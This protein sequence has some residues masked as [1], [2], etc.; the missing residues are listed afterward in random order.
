MKVYLISGPKKYA[1]QGWLFEKLKRDYTNVIS[2]YTREKDNKPQWLEKL[3]RYKV[4]I[5]VFLHAN[6]DDLIIIYDNDIIGLYLGLLFHIFR[7][8]MVVYKINAM[9]SNKEHPY[10]S[11]KRIFVR[12]AYENIFTSV[13][14]DNIASLYSEFFNLPIRHFI[15]IPDSISDFGEKIEKITDTTEKGYIFMGGAT[16]RDYTLFVEVAK[17]LPQY[18]FVAVTFEKYKRVFNNAPNNVSVYYNLCEKDFYQKIANSN[19]VFIP[20]TNDVQGGQLVVMQG[21]LLK[22]PIITTDTLAIHTYFTKESAYLIKIGD[23]KNSVKIIQELMENISL[24]RERGTAAYTAI[25]IFTTDYIYR[26]YKEKLF[27][28]R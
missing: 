26:L 4:I 1:V 16:Y 7:P 11:F 10:S 28:I 13:N 14:N 17:Q 9:T 18:R 19:I 8:H 22:K 25:K 5:S 6:K 12:M 2:L 20:L 23:V 24:R 27:K 3:S 21:A 15:S